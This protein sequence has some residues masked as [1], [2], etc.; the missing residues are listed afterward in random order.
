MLFDLS[1]RVQTYRTNQNIFY[2]KLS[3]VFTHQDLRGQPEG[4]GGV[5]KLSFT[6]FKFVRWQVP[7]YN[8]LVSK[9]I[10]QLRITK[11]HVFL[12]S[13]VTELSLRRAG[14]GLAIA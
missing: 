9:Y 12:V 6:H 14:K 10:F 4:S 8:C 7:Q 1:M 2:S 11:C 5:N 13:R 3:Q